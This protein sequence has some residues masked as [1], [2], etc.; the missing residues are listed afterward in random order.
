MT[1]GLEEDPSAEQRIYLARE[2]ER[3]SLLSP[4]R[5][6]K[7]RARPRFRVKIISVDGVTVTYR[8]RATRR[9]PNGVSTS[10]VR[11]FWQTFTPVSQSWQK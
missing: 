4:G 5:L 1:Q 6:W 7:E 10:E 3:R 2:R 11:W 8:H 9:R